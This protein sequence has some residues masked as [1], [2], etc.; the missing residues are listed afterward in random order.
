VLRNTQVAQ[1]KIED[2]HKIKDNEWHKKEAG[3]KEKT[4]ARNTRMTRSVKI[5]KHKH[6]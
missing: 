3:V 6:K 5:H 2:A 4:K 1:T